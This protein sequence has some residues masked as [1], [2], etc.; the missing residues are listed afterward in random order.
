MRLAITNGMIL[1][2]GVLEPGRNLVTEDG[3]ILGVLPRSDSPGADSV[4]DAAGAYVLPGLVDLHTHGLRDVMVDK[5]DIHR[6]SRLQA[7]NGVTT[8][9]PTLAGSPEANM[10]RMREILRETRDFSLTPNLAGFRPEIMYLADAS[11]GPAASLARPEPTLTEALWEASG[12]RIRIWDVSPELDGALPFVEWCSRHGIVSSLAHSS[13][14][15]DLVR[16]AVDAGLRLVT[17]F[18]DLFP[19][20]REVDEGVYPAGVTDYINV[21]DRL[22][23]ELIPDG[24]HVHPLLVETSLRCKGPDRVAFITDSLKGSGNPPGRYEGLVPGE[25]VEVTADRG[26]RRISDGILSGSALTQIEGFRN[27]VRKFGRTIAEAS[28]LCSRT[29]AR[30]LGL[31]NKGILAPGMDADIVILGGDLA[32]RTVIQG[33][34]VV[35]G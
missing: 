13:A 33:G 24:V 34:R 29:P 2:D 26:I 8:C 35:K 28:R 6:F 7:E 3:R 21:E 18:Y 31:H 4:I 22:S 17:H 11:G 1:V 5:D 27:A 23:V 10:S 14:G 32:I 15:I 20:P 30:L 19:Q 25:P 12:G 16:R 9:L